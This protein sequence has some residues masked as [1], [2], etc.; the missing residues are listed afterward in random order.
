MR[1]NDQV[2]VQET[3]DAGL[4]RIAPETIERA[5][6]LRE[7]FLHAEP[8]RYVFIDELFENGF[9]ETLLAEFPGFDRRLAIA[10]SGAVGG[11][12]V[13]TTIATISPGYNELYVSRLSGV[14]DLLPD[15]AMYGV[16]T[17]ENL[18]GQELDPHVD[19]NLDQTEQL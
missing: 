12:A 3:Q 10:E 1:Q 6:E 5:D 14:P 19:F 2:P 13:N 11:K 4:I 9:A 17:H 18:H 15:P 7:T 16:G 8:F